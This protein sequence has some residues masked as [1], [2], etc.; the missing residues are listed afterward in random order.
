MAKL[1]YYLKFSFMVLVKELDRWF[2]EASTNM[3][4]DIMNKW[5]EKSPKLSSYITSLGPFDIPDVPSST[6][7]WL[8]NML[9]GFIEAALFGSHPRGSDAAGITD[10]T[11]L[12]ILLLDLLTS[13]RTKSNFLDFIVS[14]EQLLATF[15]SIGIFDKLAP[16]SLIKICQALTRVRLEPAEQLV[17]FVINLG[18]YVTS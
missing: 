10:F 7:L 8:L 5:F 11:N 12:L 14:M 6:G 18:H 16:S 17:G 4:S 1:L 2:I 15:I 13:E 3:S 9:L